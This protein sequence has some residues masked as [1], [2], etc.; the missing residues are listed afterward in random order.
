MQ[1]GTSKKK[2]QRTIY[3]PE[4]SIVKIRKSKKA[5]Q[6]ESTQEIVQTEQPAHEIPTEK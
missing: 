2:R 6:P 3:V 5:E 4:T 1:A